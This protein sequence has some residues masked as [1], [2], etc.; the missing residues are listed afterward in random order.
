LS[1]I[2]FG[3]EPIVP[4]PS[5]QLRRQRVKY[6]ETRTRTRVPLA[7]KFHERAKI[8]STWDRIDS[9]VVDATL[10]VTLSNKQ[11]HEIVSVTQD[12]HIVRI[13]I[14]K[15]KDLVER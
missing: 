8:E 4:T 5:E 11:L 10:T 12:G 6:S 7:F 14:H 9:E 2:W 3:H 1:V 13:D 15:R